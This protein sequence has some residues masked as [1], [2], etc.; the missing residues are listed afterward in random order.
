MNFWEE[1]VWKLKE[2]NT[3]RTETPSHSG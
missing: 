1:H 3:K 2:G